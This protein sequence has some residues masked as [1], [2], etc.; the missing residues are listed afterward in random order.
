M[1]VELDDKDTVRDVVEHLNLAVEPEMLL[2]AVNG[3]VAELTTKL[4]EG[5]QVHLMLPISGGS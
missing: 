5:D 4:S 2:L 3:D 1:Q